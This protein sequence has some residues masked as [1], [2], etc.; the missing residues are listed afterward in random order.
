VV[1]AFTTLLV[2]LAEQGRDPA[3]FGSEM[4]IDYA[5]GPDTWHEHSAAWEQAGGGIVSI[6]AMSTGS[7]YMKVPVPNFTSPAQHIEALE[8]FMREMGG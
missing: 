7:A 1:D 2:L 3:T 8:I 5:L 6:R 4:L